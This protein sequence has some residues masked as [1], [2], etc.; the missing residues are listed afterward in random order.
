MCCVCSKNSNM[1]CVMKRCRVLMLGREI[2]EFTS[3]LDRL[4]EEKREAEKQAM[5]SGHMLRQLDSE[6]GRVSERAE[7]VSRS[8]LQRLAAE[9]TAAGR[10]LI[11]AR[12][13]DIAAAEERRAE[14]EQ[15]AG[16]GARNELAALRAAP[17]PGRANRL[18]PRGTSG[19]GWRSAIARL[20]PSCSG[21]MRWSVR[22]GSACMR[23]ARRSKRA[24]AEK[25]QREN[26]NHAR[27]STG[28]LRGGAKCRR[29]A[30]WTAA[31]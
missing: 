23:C 18:T 27:R 3:L 29:G 30:R 17:R 19:Q 20:R 8:E 7:T 24:F 21:L 31:I 26:E 9:R 11:G 16:G 4:E 25:L 13:S 5:T 14:L 22:C 1:P 15:P 2:K 12:K 6:M 10:R 28:G